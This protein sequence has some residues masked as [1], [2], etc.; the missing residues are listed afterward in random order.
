LT[1]A[2]F[3]QNGS[4]ARDRKLRKDV[5]QEAHAMFTKIVIPSEAKPRRNL[6]FEAQL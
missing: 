6:L 2:K 3:T 4:L 1:V 5:F